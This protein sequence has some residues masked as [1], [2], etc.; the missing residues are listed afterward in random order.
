MAPADLVQRQLEA[1]N[2]RALDDF[3]AT[4]SDTIEIFRLPSTAAVVSNKRE[5]AELY[6]TRVFNRPQLH[7]EIRQRIVL[8]NKVID[9]E[10]VTGLRDAP[11]EAV[12]VYEVVNDLIQR[13]WFFNPD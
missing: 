7:A 13:V 2:A 1:Y 6:A 4:Y 3:V 12:A 11:V 5:L 8:G 10:H 9:H